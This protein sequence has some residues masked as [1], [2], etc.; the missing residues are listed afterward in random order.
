M[1][2]P[3]PPFAHFLK[4]EWVGPEAEAGSLC[5]ALFRAPDV[6]PCFDR[7]RRNTA[8]IRDLLVCTHDV[9]DA[10]CVRFGA[11]FWRRLLHHADASRG[12]PR[13]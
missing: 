7:W 10:A 2:E 11:P 4:R 9:V 13:A 1:P 12:A 6:L 3:D 8:Q 5:R